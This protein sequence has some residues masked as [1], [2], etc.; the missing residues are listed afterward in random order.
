M[1]PFWLYRKH[2][3][4]EYWVPPLISERQ[5]FFDPQANPFYEHA[6]VEL[7]LAR[8]QSGQ[9]VG[10][11]AAVVN[12]NHNAV[13]EERTGF[14]GIFEVVED[15]EVAEALLSTARDW[16]QKRGMDRLRG[17][18]NLDV[19]AEIGLLVDGFDSPPVVMMTYNPP[20]YA[21]LIQRFGFE[22]AMD[23]Y[24][25]TGH[26]QDIVVRFPPK[27]KRVAEIAQKRYGVSVRKM[28]MRRFD[29]EVERIKQVYNNAWSKNWG[30]VPMTDPEIEHLALALKQIA[31]PDLLFFAE[32]EGKPVGVSV[33]LPD[34]C[35]PLLHMNGR[36]FPFGWVTF[37]R[38]R[39]K[40][41]AFRLL[42]MGVLEE[43]R[44]KGIEGLFYLET[45]K[46]ALANGYE[47]LEG[48]W[49]LETNYEIRRGIEA[50]GTH[51]YKT[52]RLYDLPIP[53]LSG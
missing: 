50:L 40:I 23:L 38:H 1:F 29:E 41:N 30:A 48:S 16:V 21:E 22:K 12:D 35:Q 14:F 43:H 8:R 44:L 49:V 5:E 9:V 39:R 20:Y 2:L 42:I 27:V 10:T 11:I 31:D 3:K 15:Y 25:Y 36:L 19:N 13:H 32:I 18:M 33:A 47:Y 28:E 17:P 37:L 24:A 45:A 4:N 34:L 51:I 6:E 26:L 46:S 7:F 53:P 52:Y